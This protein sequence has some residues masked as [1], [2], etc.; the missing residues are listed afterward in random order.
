MAETAAQA[1]VRENH[2]EDNVEASGAFVPSLTPRF[3]QELR[4]TLIRLAAYF[5]ALAALGYGGHALLTDGLINAL[6]DVHQQLEWLVPKPARNGA[7]RFH[8]SLKPKLR[9]ALDD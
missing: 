8:A 5:A 2:R 9:G 4:S 7:D 3:L 1:L 6:A